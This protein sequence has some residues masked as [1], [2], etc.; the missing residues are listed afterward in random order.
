MIN[1]E[2]F[3]N[4]TSALGTLITTSLQP[5]DMMLTLRTVTVS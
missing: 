4:A 2:I 3:D 5:L 1:Y